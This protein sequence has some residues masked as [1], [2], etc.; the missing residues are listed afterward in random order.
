MKKSY[1]LI[2]ALFV[3]TLLMNACGDKEPEEGELESCKQIVACEEKFMTFCC[4][5]DL[6]CH[7]EVDGN[8]FPDTEEG[9]SAAAEATT[10]EAKKSVSEEENLKNIIEKLEA[11]RAEVRGEN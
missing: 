2:V 8:Q 6:N 3:S 4:D 7:Y 10:C 1:V 11:L 9:K 5:D